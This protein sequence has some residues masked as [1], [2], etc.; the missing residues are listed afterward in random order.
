VLSLELETLFKKRSRNLDEVKT[1]KNTWNQMKNFFRVVWNKA[2]AEGT[3]VVSFEWTDNFYLNQTWIPKNFLPITHNNETI[4]GVETV[5]WNVFS[6]SDPLIQKQFSNTP[7]ET[8]RPSGITLNTIFYSFHSPHLTSRL[9]KKVTPIPK[10]QKRKQIQKKA[11]GYCS[12]WSSKFS[13]KAK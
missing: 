3:G 8:A 11:T 12:H 2:A 7:S 4:S 1:I 10:L 5:M 9:L 6:I 13:V